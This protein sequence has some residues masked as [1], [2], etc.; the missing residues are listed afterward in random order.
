MISRL[1]W[2]GR[3][4][5]H[6]DYFLTIFWCSFIYDFIDYFFFDVS[7]S[8]LLL[9]AFTMYAAGRHFDAWCRF[10]FAGASSRCALYRFSSLFAFFIFFF[11]DFSSFFSFFSLICLCLMLTLSDRFSSDWWFHFF[12]DIF[13]LFS[14]AGCW[15]IVSIDW[16]RRRRGFRFS[17]IFS[18]FTAEGLII[19]FFFAFGRHFLIGRSFLFLFHFFLMGLMRRLLMII[20]FSFGWLFISTFLHFWFSLIIDVFLDFLH[21]FL[22]R[23]FHLIIEYFIS[24]D[25]FHFHFLLLHFYYADDISCADDIISFFFSVIQDEPRKISTKLSVNIYRWVWLLTFSVGE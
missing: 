6:A 4:M 13:R 5:S 25:V 15:L 22:R 1:I 21:W 16:F 20:Y 17:F 3:L 23:F 19:D 11:A 24:I 14:D 8:L 2:W 7:S 12:F 10:F 18:L 9:F